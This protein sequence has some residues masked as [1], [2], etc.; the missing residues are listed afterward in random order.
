MSRS[1]LGRDARW[2]TAVLLP[3]FLASG[4]AALIYEVLWL[5]E[6]GLLFGN[7]PYAAATTLAVFFLGMATGSWALGRRSGMLQNPLRTYALLECGIAASALLYFALLPLFHRIHPALQ[8]AVGES[9]V[10]STLVKL[11]LSL[12]ILFPPAFFMGGT[13]PVMGQ[14]LIRRSSDLGRLGTLLY[15]ANTLGAAAGALAAGFF[16]PPAL[17]FRRSYLVA[18]TLNLVIAGIA[19]I[20]GRRWRRPADPYPARGDDAARATEHVGSGGRWGDVITVLAFLS[21]LL[22][23]GLEVVWTRMFA[24][25]LH[26]SVYSFTAILVTFLAALALGSALAHVLCRLPIA[27]PGKVLALLALCGWVL[28]AATPLLFVRWTD[29]L[30]EVSTAAGFW[31]YVG[32]VLGLAAAVMLGPGILVGSVYPFLLKASEWIDRAPGHTLGRLASINAVGGVVG[33]LLS[34]F[35][36]LGAFGLWRSIGILAAGYL[37]IAVI[38]SRG[39]ITQG[40]GFLHA[41]TAVAVMAGGVVLYVIL[42]L[43]LPSNGV[44]IEPGCKVVESWEGRH[45]TVAVIGDGR[46]RW[47]TVDNHYTLGSLR[48]ISSEERQ[49]QIPLFVQPDPQSV[50]FIGMGTGITAGAA[51]SFPVERVVTSELIPEVVTAARSHFVEYSNGLFTDPRSSIVIEDGR[52]YL[53]ST[54]EKFDVIISDLFVPWHAGTGSLYTREHFE[55]CRSRLRPGGLFVQWLP[56]CLLS[57]SEFSMIAR[58]VLD[59]F[60]TVTVWRGEMTPVF[61]SL[62]LLCTEEAVLD[63]EAVRR[64]L[65]R[66]IPPRQRTGSVTESDVLPYIMYAGNLGASRRILAGE[67]LNIDDRPL[68]EYRSPI[69]HQESMADGQAEGGEAELL[70]SYAFVALLQ[71]LF[72]ETPPESDPFLARLSDEQVTYVRAGLHLYTA[73]VHL[74][75]GRRTEAAAVYKEFLAA[76]PFNIYPHLVTR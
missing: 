49:S 38:A 74:A 18:I 56:V 45:G 61:P 42:P 64:N 46:N 59:V 40:V 10:A 28:T 73:G 37:A 47:I 67:R 19:W 34:G 12:L 29:G 32:R 44:R 9:F 25:V 8:Q 17:G 5:K 57:R 75:A 51:L 41:A 72:D 48:S 36:L 15:G 23:L 3:V 60:P 70:R 58:T 50:F 43:G 27:H 54:P 65:S 2:E 6:L 62:A 66:V 22:V 1:A 16:L 52:Q 76:V 20:A 26:N 30:A 53:S 13:L 35:A 24:Q 4:A 11:A 68:I 55:I 33:S 21:G 63:P 39:R 31:A 69:T 7:T 71:Q 14:Q